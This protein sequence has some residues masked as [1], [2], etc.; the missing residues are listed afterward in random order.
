M[1][2]PR[3]RLD[4]TLFMA[5]AARSSGKPRATTGAAV[6]AEDVR[7]GRIHARRVHPQPDLPGGGLGPV[8]LGDA[9]GGR[10]AEPAGL[11]VAHHS[12]CR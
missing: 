2:L 6:P 7:V 8:T 9:Q 1:S 3:A 12:L 4:M 11:D 5:S 10:I